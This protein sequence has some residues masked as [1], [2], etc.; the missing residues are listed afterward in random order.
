[1]EAAPRA[2]HLKIAGT[3]TETNGA[4]AGVHT[5]LEALDCMY[6]SGLDTPVF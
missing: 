1:M 5:V 6:E 2:I 4:P 3:C